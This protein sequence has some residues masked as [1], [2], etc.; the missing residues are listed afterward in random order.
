M[1]RKLT[2][3]SKSVMDSI[4]DKL[5]RD[6]IFGLQKGRVAMASEH[7]NCVIIAGLCEK[8]SKFAPSIHIHDK[9]Y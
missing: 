4:L 6:R 1:S 8:N 3:P 2:G 5:L 9:M 7:D